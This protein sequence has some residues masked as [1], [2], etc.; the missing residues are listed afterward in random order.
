M[1][2]FVTGATGFIGSHF[3]RTALAGGHEVRALRRP[4]SRTRLPLEREPEWLERSLDQ[5]TVGDL[6]GCAAI[7][8][9]ASPGVSPQKAGWEELLYWNVTAAV[10]LAERAREAGVERIVAAGTFAEYGRSADR[11]DLVPP[12]APLAPTTG[13]AASK[14]AA[15]AALSAYAI[16]QKMQ[17]AY[18]RVF[19]AYGEGQHAANFWPALRAAALAGGDFPM[20]AGEQIRDY[21]PVESVAATFCRVAS[22]ASLVAGEPLVANVGSG[23]PVTMR[24][25]AEEWWAR[26][27]ARGQLRIGALPYRPNEVMRFV[28]LLQPL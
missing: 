24:A 8:H 6:A 25:F 17:L 15:Y 27:G 5:V 21:V 26:F 20:T 2:L 12:D 22:G 11:Y 14:A 28:P 7:V 16:E 18:L 23:C 3:L 10:R 13:Y 9:L 1:Q 4:G 19:S